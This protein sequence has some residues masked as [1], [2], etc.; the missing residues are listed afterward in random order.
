MP[1][2]VEEESEPTPVEEPKKRNK[3]NIEK[4]SES[5]KKE[6]VWTTKKHEGVKYYAEKGNP[7]SKLYEILSGGKRGRVVGEMKDKKKIIY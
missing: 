1:T 7:K 4:D 3:S 6:I 5:D 2:H